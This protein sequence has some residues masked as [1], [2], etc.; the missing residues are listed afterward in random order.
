M[1]LIGLGEFSMIV[2]GVQPPAK[3]AFTLIEMLAVITIILILAALTLGV[4]KY[5]VDR[6]RLAKAEADLNRRAADAAAHHRSRGYYAGFSVSGTDPWGRPYRSATF[7]VANTND[8]YGGDPADF[9]QYIVYSYGPDA[10]PG[11]KGVDDD[12]DSRTDEERDLGNTNWIDHTEVG[13][14]DDVVVG[15]SGRKRGFPRR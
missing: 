2:P 5:A 10:K 1:A 6:S 9:Q 12:G 4:G 13:Y 14:G 8:P 7:N 15:N 3:R 11:R